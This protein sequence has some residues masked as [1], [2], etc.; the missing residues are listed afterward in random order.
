MMTPKLYDTI[1]LIVD[2]PHDGLCAGRQGAIVHQY[3]DTAFEVEFANDQGETDHLCTLQTVQFIIVWQSSTEKFVPVA[4][5]I[6]QLVHRL[7]EQPQQQLFDLARSLTA[8]K[9]AISS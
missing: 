4:D 5:R 2:L 9:L 6:A 3:D 7:P 1:E 8:Q